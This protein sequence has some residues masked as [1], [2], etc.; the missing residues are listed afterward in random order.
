MRFTFLNPT[1][2]KSITKLPI[3]QNRAIIAAKST[4]RII[5]I[6]LFSALITLCRNRKNAPET[7]PRPVQKRTSFITTIK[8]VLLVGTIKRIINKKKKNGEPFSIRI[9]FE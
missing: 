6:G 9:I 8:K 5:P 2:L 1:I 4:T 3:L 7:N